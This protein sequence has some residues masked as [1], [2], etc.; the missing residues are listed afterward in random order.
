MNDA[1]EVERDQANAECDQAQSRAQEA[2]EAASALCKADGYRAGEG[3]PAAS[4]GGVARRAKGDV[5]GGIASALLAAVHLPLVQIAIAVISAAPLLGV[6]WWL[7]WRLPKREVNRLRPQ[8]RDPKARVDVEGSFRKTIG[9]AIGGAAVLVGAAFA[10]LQFVD[11]QQATHA[12]LQ[13]SHDLLISNQVSKGFEVTG[14][15]GKRT[16]VVIA[17]RLM[18][19]AA[20]VIIAHWRDS[21]LRVTV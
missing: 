6:I 7:W 9:Q 19:I 20:T 14:R 12:Q 1:V 13:A 8:I 2:E 3:P 5:M 10:H 15:C 4:P 16:F 17:A 11:Q 21:R 18:L